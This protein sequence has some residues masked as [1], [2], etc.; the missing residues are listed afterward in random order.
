MREQQDGASTS[1]LPLRGGL[2]IGQGLVPVPGQ[3]LLSQ[4]RQYSLPDRGQSS[5]K[6][7]SRSDDGHSKEYVG[8]NDHSSFKDAQHSFL[9][10]AKG[11]SKI[12]K[13]CIKRL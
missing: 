11:E 6:S 7:S 13:P 2:G 10:D 12:R 1:G 4:E 3:Q 8:K 5:G 9:T